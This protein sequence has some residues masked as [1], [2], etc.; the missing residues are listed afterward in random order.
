MITFVTE[1]ISDRMERISY[2]FRNVL[3]SYSFLRL[4]FDFWSLTGLKKKKKITNKWLSNDVQSWKYSGHSMMLP[5]N[6]K[7][8]IIH[9]II[10]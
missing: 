10:T 2:D 6:S 7:C 3:W 4:V 5:V 1:I 8:L 9:C